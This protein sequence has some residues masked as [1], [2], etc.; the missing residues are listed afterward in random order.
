MSFC[1]LAAW[2]LFPLYREKIFSEVDAHTN[3]TLTVIRIPAGIANGA[4]QCLDVI[5]VFKLW[6]KCNLFLFT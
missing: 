4:P 1:Q 3:K 2:S 6:V 5:G